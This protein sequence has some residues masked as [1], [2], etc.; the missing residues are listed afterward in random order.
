LRRFA[1]A[2][3]CPRGRKLGKT[4][5]KPSNTL[6]DRPQRHAGAEHEPRSEPIDQRAARQL[7]GGIG[8]QKRRQQQPHV[9]NREA[10]ILPNQWVGDRQRR[11]VD[12]VEGATQQ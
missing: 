7:A 3:K 9:R 2:E 5:D 10:E 4:P 11:T 6:G 1:K 12:V 8:P